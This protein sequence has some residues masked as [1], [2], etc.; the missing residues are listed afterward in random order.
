MSKTTAKELALAA[1]KRAS[2]SNVGDTA[3]WTYSAPE[4]KGRILLIHGFR[5]DHHGLEAIA[6]ALQDYEV[7]IPDLPGYGK[8]K[9]FSGIHDL[10][11]YGIWLADLCAE[12][13]EVN[14][15]LG[16][17]FGSLVVAN[18]YSKGLGVS[19]VALLNPI[20]TRSSEQKDFANKLSSWFYRFCAKTGSVGSLL[21]RAPLIVRG[22]SIVMT[23][24]RQ[25]RV[26]SF[27][28]GQH[29]KYFSSY[30]EDRVAFEGFTAASNGSVFDYLDALPGKVLL[31]A[32]S[33]DLIAPL[34]NQVSLQARL[35]GSILEVIP[36]VGHLTHYESPTKVAELIDQHLITK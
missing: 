24:S 4:P 3:L 29:A 22:M 26:R 1:T 6:G 35:T 21:L 31:I 30:R 2:R 9:S 33:N 13:P 19:N 20:T 8:S 34:A 15:V 17:S 7:L 16:H 10:D 5:G 11:A 28:H 25:L 14:L 18:G 23:T 27:V 12:L 32:G 36:S